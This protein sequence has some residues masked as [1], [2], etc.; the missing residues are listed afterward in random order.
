MAESSKSLKLSLSRLPRTSSQR[1]GMVQPVVFQL[2]AQLPVFAVPSPGLVFQAAAV[3][4]FT[5][6]RA[7]KRAAAGVPQGSVVRRKHSPACRRAAL[8][9]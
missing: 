4:V 5:S 3:L 2:P 7:A 6:Q 1:L 8:W 9:V